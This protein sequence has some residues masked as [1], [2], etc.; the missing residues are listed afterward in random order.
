[1]TT[2]KIMTTFVNCKLN[3]GVGAPNIILMDCLHAHMIRT[4]NTILLTAIILI[5]SNDF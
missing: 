5:L 2:G 1:M 4:K 3:Q